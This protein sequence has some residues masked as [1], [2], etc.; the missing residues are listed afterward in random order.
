MHKKFT[1]SIRTVLI[2]LFV[3]QI[4]LT[5]GFVGYITLN[6]SEKAVK[7]IALQLRSEVNSKIRTHLT[8]FL[9][10]PEKLNHLNKR[11]IIDNNLNIKRQDALMTHFL[12]Q[13][14]TF[15]TINSIYF[16]N[17]LGGLANAGR[18]SNSD[19]YFFISTDDFES[20]I[21]RKYATDSTKIKQ[22][23]LASIPFFDSRTRPWYQNAEKQKKLV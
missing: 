10:I 17:T 20:G 2:L 18:E 12:E 19:S 1:L 7:N 22:T 5:A 13:V 8:N 3:S 9:Q 23:L 14:F 11:A 16:G 15:P 4:I 6:N 21:F